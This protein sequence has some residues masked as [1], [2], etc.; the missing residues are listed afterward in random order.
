MG[1]SSTTYKKIGKE[2]GFSYGITILQL[3][4]APLIVAMLTRVLTPGRY[5]AY[6]L[7][8][9]LISFGAMVLQMGMSQ[10]FLTK[11]HSYKEKKWPI[12][13]FSILS[14]VFAILVSFSVVFYFTPIAGFFLQHA[15]L[16]G[17][18]TILGL[19]LI[20][21]IF[22]TLGRIY[23]YYYKA[24]QKINI[25]NFM[26]LLRTQGLALPLLF[27]Y[28]LY[29]QFNLAH[30]FIAWIAFSLLSLVIYAWL[31]KKDISAFL[32]S[33]INFAEIPP[34]YRFSLPIAL[35]AVFGWVLAYSDRFIL[36]AYTSTAAVGIYSVAG[37]ILGILLTFSVAVSNV[38]VPYFAEAWW[39]NKKEYGMYLNALLKYG[40]FILIPGIVGAIALR[41][42]LVTLL[43]GPQY[44]GAAPIVIILSPYP[45]FAFL[46]GIFGV[47]LFLQDKPRLALYLSF[48]GAAIDIG[49]ALLLVP[50][51]GMKGAAAA[52]VLGNLFIFAA[53]FY[54]S[55]SAGLVNLRFMKL[56]QILF[57]ALAMGAVLM[58][59]HPENIVQKLLTL[60]FGGGI[61]FA[62]IFLTKTFDQGEL[63][64]IK[65]LFSK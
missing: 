62:L 8:A 24:R 33:G 6:V 37:S 34:A 20:A 43:A 45:I 57:S 38:I 13:F 9:A 16:A 23:D 5:G 42:E 49:L 10:F 54:S 1:D 51:Y 30:V 21:I 61:Y 14:S 26:E 12:V 29:G 55:K 52:L 15:K 48:I 64:V 22:V 28:I 56:G 17:Y 7:F 25:A 47:S 60:L 53:L 3:L 32:A 11:L 31:D 59:L 50:V 2:I 46:N 19:S 39:K 36:S 58:F 4:L 35:S 65:S 63:K 41:H 18:S 27:L 40:F 44:L